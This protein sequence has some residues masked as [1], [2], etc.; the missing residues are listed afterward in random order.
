MHKEQSL[1][2]LF[3]NQAST[4]PLSGF[5]LN[6]ILTALLAALLHQFYIRFGT[7]M[8]NRELFGK[9][10]VLLALTTMLVITLV[11][12]SLALSLGLV[13]AL[14]IIRF[15]AA[16]KEPEEL[17]YLFLAISLGLGFGAQQGPITMIAFLVILLI[18]AA[19]SLIRRK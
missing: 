9:N 10:F 3:T 1:L 8:S 19:K 16:I 12:S 7:S 5:L 4:I 15:R 6:F 13:G 14:S 17:S 11:K 2:E 18:L